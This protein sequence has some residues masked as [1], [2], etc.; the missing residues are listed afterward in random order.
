MNDADAPANN[1]PAAV[2]GAPTDAPPDFSQKPPPTETPKRER[3]RPRHERP[4]PAPRKPPL[5]KALE[6][7][8]GMISL[9]VMATGDTYCANHI[10][11]QAEPLAEA[12]SE[13][14]KVNPRVKA[15][16]ERMLETGAW[17]AVIITT[18]ATVI[19]ICY[20]HGMWPGNIPP[21]FSFGLGPA[22]PPSPEVQR[23]DGQ[24]GGTPNTA[25]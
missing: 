8:F 10:A 6:D 24:D 7:A 16:L 3:E 18:A 25:T 14:A 11:A 9:A 4:T 15:I 23:E 20:H 13:L 22:P 5:K 2:T 17:S 21:P 12:W 19:P 1:S